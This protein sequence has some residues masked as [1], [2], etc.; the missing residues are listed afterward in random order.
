VLT[1]SALLGAAWA[2][3]KRYMP[4]EV[5]EMLVAQVQQNQ[6]QIQ[7][8]TQQANAQNWLLFWQMQVTQ[9]TGECA[10]N[11]GSQVLRQQLNHAIK[12]RDIWQ[13]EVNRLM[14]Q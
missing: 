5:T 9:K 14:N 6:M 2:F 1:I 13:K 4:R 11:P 3:D 10:A 7:K 12:Q 8:N